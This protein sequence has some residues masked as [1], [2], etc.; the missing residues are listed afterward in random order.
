MDTRKL[1]DIQAWALESK[2]A[3]PVD[4][5]ERVS[6]MAPI[7]AA[8]K[9]LKVLPDP[10]IA[11]TMIEMEDDFLKKVL[12][13]MTPV[14][15]AHILTF[16]IDANDSA[17]LLGM[18]DEAKKNEILEELEST[19]QA[20][21]II[22]VMSYDA[23]TAGRMMSKE[24]IKVNVSWTLRKCFVEIRRQAK[25]YNRI[26]SIYVVDDRDRLMGLLSLKK[27]IVT[28][29][30]ATIESL[31]KPN[32]HYTEV[33]ENIENVG[34]IM[35][36]Y[37][38]LAI[39]VINEARVLVGMITLDDMIDV[40]VEEADK[41]FQLSSGISD[42]VEVKD[43]IITL[44]K[45]RLPW[46]IIGLC[47]GIISSKV[48]SAFE[49]ESYI[50]LASFIPL[51]AAMGG[52]VGMQ[53]AAIIVQ[54]LAS[55]SIVPKDITRILYK[56]LILG[57]LNGILFAVAV[58]V[59]TWLIGYQAI[60]GLSIGISLVTVT[61]FSAIFGSFIPLFIKR[62]NRDPAV[63]TGPLITTANDILGLLIYFAISLSILS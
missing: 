28:Q 10:L 40:V 21:D 2:N 18:L 15:I 27:L 55:N 23:D 30:H 13:E 9:Y 8:V 54:G 41:D 24:I 12:N 16:D 62:I 52:N 33:S 26:Y 35:K 25:D 17:Y 20:T 1:P 31:Y 7:E 46:L 61:V 57:L 19:Q 63:A 50:V 37:D 39:P 59:F 53:S 11:Q 4:L 44:S 32:I 29:E 56:E 38:L 48:V 34:L 36:K 58:F 51:I 22:Q 45:A 47:G 43:G 14:S 3:H 42:D 49:L 60:V 6:T 5:A